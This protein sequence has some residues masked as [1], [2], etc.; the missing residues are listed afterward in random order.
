MKPRLFFFHSN[1]FPAR[2]YGHFLKTLETWNPEA[3]NI[4]GADLSSLGGTMD[5]MVEEVISQAAHAKGNAI[6]IGH[7]LGRESLYPGPGFAT[8]FIPEYDFAR[9]SDFQPFEKK[10]HPLAAKAGDSGM[11]QSFKEGPMTTKHL[12]QKGPSPGVFY[13]QTFI[14]GLSQILT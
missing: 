12:Y 2:T 9:S 7:S 14:S 13:S 6:G 11:V 8:E 5:P 1:G 10:C 3:I 4:L